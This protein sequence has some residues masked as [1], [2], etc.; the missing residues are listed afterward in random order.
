M[1]TYCK[2]FILVFLSVF[3]ILSSQSVAYADSDNS[4]FQEIKPEV[5]VELNEGDLTAY[6][7]ELVNN[8]RE[9]ASLPLFKID[10]SLEG[11]AKEYANKMARANLA[12]HSVDGKGMKQRAL[13]FGIKLSDNFK[14]NNFTE[15]IAWGSYGCLKGC[16]YNPYS[17]MERRITEFVNEKK[18]NGPHYRTIYHPDFNAVGIGIAIVPTSETKGKFFVA[19]EYAKLDNIDTPAGFFDISSNNKNVEAIRYLRENK[20][21]GGRDNF[22]FPSEAITRAE[23]LKIFFNTY[24]IPLDSNG[25]MDFT[26]VIKADW[27]YPYVLTAINR[28]FLSGYNDKSFKPNNAVSKVEAI[29]ILAQLKH[30]YLP[31][32]TLVLFNDVNK[33]D[34]YSPYI[35][36]VYDNKLMDFDSMEFGVN[37]PILRS[38]LAEMIYRVR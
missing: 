38:Q 32:N 23:I 25:T 9:E 8:K 20:I 14:L 11:L 21:I 18:Y 3:L 2:K 35:A 15:N 10:K 4:G 27:Y 1:T 37:E 34:W 26:D 28:G 13:D 7:L 19:W 29:K 22:F 31:Q 5:K 12:T 24:K 6:A 36:Y 17:E 30:L 16:T 33:N